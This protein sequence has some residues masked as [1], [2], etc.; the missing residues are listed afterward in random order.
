MKAEKAKK[1]L[2]KYIDYNIETYGGFCLPKVDEIVHRTTTDDKRNMD[3]YTFSY[4]M[5]IAY[6][7]K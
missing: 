5:S 7:V 4:L 6:P 3:S 2:Q 1:L